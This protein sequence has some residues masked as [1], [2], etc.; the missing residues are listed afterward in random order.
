MNLSSSKI[1]TC[2]RN[3][4]VTREQ[5]Q[6]CIQLD[7]IT[8]YIL[9]HHLWSTL[10]NALPT[11]VSSLPIF[12]SG[13]SDITPELLSFM[14]SANLNSPI[15]VTSFLFEQIGIGTG[16]SGLLYRLYNIRYSTTTTTECLPQ[17]LVIKLSTAIWMG[18]VASVEPDFYWKLGP[19]ISNIEIPKCYYTARNPH[20]P[21][22]SLLLLEDLSL[23]YEPLGPKASLND[24]TLFFLIA[25][26]ASLHAEFYK[27]PL[28]R[29]ETFA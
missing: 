23:N 8:T 20:S 28:L 27:H 22:K 7:S 15:K 5:L 10:P 29:E 24:S 3:P 25:S 16:W 6:S 18:R 14:I 26:I 17:C 21:N 12:P 13:I 19:R 4:L 11:V 2:A 1:R 9:Q